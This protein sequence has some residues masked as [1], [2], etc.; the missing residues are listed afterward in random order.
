MWKRLIETSTDKYGAGPYDFVLSPT[1]PKS[2]PDQFA[3]NIEHIPFPGMSDVL[4]GAGLPDRIEIEL[5][6]PEIPTHR[7]DHFKLQ[8]Y[9][10]L[11]GHYE[12][13]APLAFKPEGTVLIFHEV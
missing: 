12:F 1:D 6:K 10:A 3:K 8:E 2:Y 5:L 4:D 7:V 11:K 13:L 9:S